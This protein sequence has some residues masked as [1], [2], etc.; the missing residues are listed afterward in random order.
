MN[1]LK[2]LITAF[3]TALEITENDVNDELNYNN[4]KQWDSTAHMILIARLEA[5]FDVLFEVEDILEM[6]SLSKAKELHRHRKLTKKQT[7]H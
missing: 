4:S 1:A 6:S 7:L 3:V 2:K 5:D